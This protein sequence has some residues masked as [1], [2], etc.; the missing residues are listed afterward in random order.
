M[1]AVKDAPDEGHGWRRAAGSA[2][3]H[4][5]VME[6]FREEAENRMRTLLKRG[7]SG[8][9]DPVECRKVI[10]ELEKIFEWYSGHIERH[11]EEILQAFPDSEEKRSA[12]AR[13]RDQIRSLRGVHWSSTGT[14]PDLPGFQAASGREDRGDR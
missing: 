8:V 5:T 1:P 4:A 11:R 2:V 3:Y 12:V 14:V 9:S 13:G 10:S 7:R 6:G